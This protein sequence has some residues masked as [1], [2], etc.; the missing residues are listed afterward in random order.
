MS[1]EPTDAELP[2]EPPAPKAPVDRSA[3]PKPWAQL[4]F[5]TFQPAIFSRMLAHT[6][7]GVRAGDFVAVYDKAGNRV[8]AGLYNQN[9]KIPLRVVCHS[10]E[11]VGEEYFAAALRRAVALRR[12]MFQLDAVTDAY[13]VVNSDGDGVSGLTIDR[14]GDVLFCD[15]Y[16]L[17]IFQR[18]PRWLPLL[19][20]LCGTKREIVHRRRRYRRVRGHPPVATGA[21]M[22]R[23]RC[24]SPSTV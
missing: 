23:G 6:S 20:E 22:R 21:E 14:Y 5:F 1:D 19:H 11:P 18:L 13:R 16:S 7:P 10:T 4:K 12:E 15:V 3:W 9:A 2:P 24:G 17:G 8:G